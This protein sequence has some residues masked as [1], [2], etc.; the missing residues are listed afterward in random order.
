MP[1]AT[2]LAA[3]PQRTDGLDLVRAQVHERRSHVLLEEVAAGRGVTT[4]QLA[5][6]WLLAQGEHVV[7]IPGTKRRT[8]LEQNVAAARVRLS[9]DAVEA[10][11]ALWPRDDVRGQRHPQMELLGG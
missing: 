1:L 3:R 6:A 7:P 11:G 9:P 4:A 2:D 8:Y 5:L 10:I